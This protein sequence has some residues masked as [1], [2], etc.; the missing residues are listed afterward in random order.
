VAGE[1][2][3]SIISPVYR[4]ERI[5]DELVRRVSE[6]VQA[7]TSQYEIILVEDGSPDG[8]WRAVEK[9]CAQDERVKGIKFS[10]NFGQHY[11]ITAGLR[12][13]KGKMA[14]VIDC[15]LQD[16]P[17]YIPELVAK[18]REGFDIVYT[19]KRDRRHNRLKDFVARCYFRVFNWLSDQRQDDKTGAYSLIT[20][21][22]ID[23][24]CR[25]RDYHRHYL[26]IL[27]LLGFRHASIDIEHHP[28]YEGKSSYNYV[29]L[30]RLALDGIVSQSDRL[31][32]VSVTLGFTLFVLSFLWA[33]WLVIMYFVRGALPGYTSLMAM[34]L[35]S[36]GLLLMSIGV[37]GI[38]IG[39]IFAQVKERPL[40]F[41]E[42]EVNL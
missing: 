8:S 3:I 30:L 1:I 33:A 24:F 9:A 39:K 27:Q 23:A 5:V 19:R 42:K 17:K 32:R 14:V 4:A 25:I 12:T 21:P 18:A 37:T 13:C 36:T 40:Y 10:R 15:D 7:I 41:I 35:L 29:K 2:E 26:P 31:L 28:R 11:A 20:R 6:A 38:Y 16:D 22:V 34:L